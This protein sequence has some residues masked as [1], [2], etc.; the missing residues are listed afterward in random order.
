[1]KKLMLLPVLGILVLVPGDS[2][3]W[4]RVGGGGFRAGGVY[5]TPSFSGY[6]GGAVGYRG[7]AVGYRGAVGAVGYR[8]GA[9]GY[10]GA[11]GYG[12]AA[13]YRGGAVGY[14]GYRGWTGYHGAAVARP[15][16]ASRGIYVNRANGYYRPGYAYYH[17]YYAN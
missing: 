15:T 2:S 9:V 11:V 12:G 8:G 4:G 1:M 13:G 16:Y 17:P 6:R 10:R 5:H 7:G 14:G 3:G